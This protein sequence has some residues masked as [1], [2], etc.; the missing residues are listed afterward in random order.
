MGSATDYVTN[1]Y[2]VG[3]PPLRMERKAIWDYYRIEFLPNGYPGRRT[4]GVLMA[5]PI[6]GPYVITDYLIQ[7]GLTEDPIFLEAA[8]RVADISVAMMEPLHDGLVFNYDE[9]RAKVSSKKGTWYSGLTQSRYVDVL[10][11]L[12]AYPD[13]ER[14]RGPLKAVLTSLTIPVE[15]GGVARYTSDGGLIIEEYPA[16]FPNCTL[17]GW[18][19]ATCILLDVAKATNDDGDWEVFHKSVRGME[20]VIGLYD[21]PELANSRYK[22]EGDAT[23][24]LTAAGS[25]LEVTDCHVVVPSAGVFAANVDGDQA[26]EALKAG[27]LAIRDGKLGR[28]KVRLSRFS[29]PSP[30]RL[31]LKVTAERAAQVKVA[32][33]ETTYNPFG[34]VPKVT[35]Q[36]HLQ[37]FDLLP[38]EN[39]LEIAVPWIAAEMVA[40]PTNFSKKLT[41]R[42]FNVYHFIHIDTL[43]K[44]VEQSGSEIL[45][46]YLDKWR[47]APSLWA[48]H[49]AYQDE[50][51][52]LERF[53]MHKHK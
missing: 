27:P 28:V 34:S 12:L 23:F 7:Y 17:N 19:T 41:G 16:T 9:E 18:T 47:H 36:K 42:Q 11:R 6:Y 51:L 37:E 53:D 8:I 3:L 50:R 22:L 45:G 26:G 24:Q 31:L 48:E 5:H 15:D 35:G 32:I 30:N 43:T 10:S 4:D 49:P 40:H 52:M 29:W 13:T 21:V 1:E 2:E 39:L 44:I 33:G 46:Y 20:S 14:F 25:D 38:G